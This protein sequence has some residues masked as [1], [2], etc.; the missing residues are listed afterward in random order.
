MFRVKLWLNW[1]CE[2]GHPLPC[3][4]YSSERLDI[5]KVEFGGASQGFSN[6]ACAV[7]LLT[8]LQQFRAKTDMRVTTSGLLIISGVFRAN[9]GQGNQ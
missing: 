5:R 9:D 2:G 1:C 6:S 8:R 7:E 3:V 4:C